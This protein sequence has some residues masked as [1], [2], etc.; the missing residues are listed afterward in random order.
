M[1]K[2]LQIDSLNEQV[3]LRQ[4]A[5]EADDQAYFAAVDASR[6]HLSQFGDETARRYPTVASVTKARLNPEN[7][8]ELRM[9][10]WHEETFVGSA[11]LTPDEA[12]TAEIG[13]W[14]DV[15]HTGKGYATLATNALAL[16]A[17]TRYQRVCARIAEENEAADKLLERVNFALV[18]RE[19]GSLVFERIAMGGPS[20][21]RA[22]DLPAPVR[23]PVPEQDL[24]RFA[25]MPNTRYALRA[26]DKDNRTVFL[27]YAVARKRYRCTC[28]EGD[29]AIG[30][31]HVVFGIVQE[32]TRF[33][34]HHAD[35]SCAQKVIL[36]KCTQI[37]VVKPRDASATATNARRRKYRHRKRNRGQSS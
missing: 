21:K 9:G 2:P 19:A 33:T 6:E 4:L 17:V 35:F 7:P 1:D 18:A 26:K 16:Y 36:P 34:H 25:D 37:E 13:C 24:E 10:I 29:I 14:L 27:S 15:R 20:E 11:R 5:T 32:S 28:C 22:P 23:P 12:G 31:S 3:V 30:S 8:D